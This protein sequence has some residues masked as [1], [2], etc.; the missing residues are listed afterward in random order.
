MHIV[1]DP[2][3]I[4]GR[5]VVTEH[6]ERL[7][8]PAGDLGN[9]GHEVVGNSVRILPDLATGMGAD[10]VEV[11]QQYHREVLVC[12]A[13]VL[14][15]LLHHAF[16]VSVRV[17]GSDRAIFRDRKSFRGAVDGGGGGE[18]KTPALVLL[19]NAQERQRTPHV[20]RIVLQ[21]AG[22][23]FAHRLEGRKMNSSPYGGFRG[24]HLVQR[25]LVLDIRAVHLH[26]LVC[27]CL[28]APYCLFFT[29]AKVVDHHHLKPALKKQHTGVG[30]YVS[31]SPR[32]YNLS[33]L[34]LSLECSTHR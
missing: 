25:T 13:H 17:G 4:G 1:A 2:G 10:G 9:K 33:F 3:A 21:G 32:H 6:H 22:D 34:H 18:D 28:Y 30:A 19:H 12:R 11:A 31:C 20:V 15:Y 7:P 29:I 27:Q 26:L 8:P 16:G 5:P 24:V 14:H 23:R